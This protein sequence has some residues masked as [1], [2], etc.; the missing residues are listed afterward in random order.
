M[1]NKSK[2]NKYLYYAAYENKI[3]KETMDIKIF[4]CSSSLFVAF[5]QSHI[6]E[7]I[8]IINIVCGYKDV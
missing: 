7:N 5:Y 3:R 1:Q 4:F 8:I 6:E 2:L